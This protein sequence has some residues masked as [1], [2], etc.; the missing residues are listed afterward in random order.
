MK[1]TKIQTH[2]QVLVLYSGISMHCV[3][4][5]KVKGKTNTDEERRYKGMGTDGK[6]MG[7]ECKGG[8][9]M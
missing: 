5:V 4:V 1:R 6:A 8:T 9:R 2:D 3:S 7:A